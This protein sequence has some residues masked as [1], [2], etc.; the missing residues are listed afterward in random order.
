MSDP[1]GDMKKAIERIQ[2]SKEERVELH[3]PQCDL[4]M[5]LGPCSCIPIIQY[6]LVD[7]NKGR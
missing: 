7:K 5:G 6:A 4:V 3:H 1:I 2:N